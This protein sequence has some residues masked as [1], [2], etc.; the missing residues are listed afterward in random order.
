MLK[1][2]HIP[3]YLSSIRQNTP[4]CNGNTAPFGG[5]ILGSN[6]SG[7]AP[8]KPRKL[9]GHAAGEFFEVMVQLPRRNTELKARAPYRSPDLCSSGI[10]LFGID[11]TRLQPNCLRPGR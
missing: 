9:S 4:W 11:S 3:R 10:R 2:S 7:V 1:S 5:V 8:R 6:P